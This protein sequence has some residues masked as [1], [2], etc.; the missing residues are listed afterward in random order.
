M[1]DS[2][3]NVW[4]KIETAPRD[5][6]ILV[7]L[8]GDDKILGRVT[9]CLLKDGKPFYVGSNFYHD[10]PYQPTHWMNIPDAPPIN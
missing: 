6:F 10:R 3:K 8:S 2:D 1:G 5:G 7:Y 4:Q 9:S